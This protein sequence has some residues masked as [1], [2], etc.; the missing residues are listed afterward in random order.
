MKK[1]IF[2]VMLL[3]IVLTSNAQAGWFNTASVDISASPDTVESDQQTTLT[4]TSSDAWAAKIDN[5]GGKVDLNGSILVS[6]SETTTYEIT[7]RGGFFGILCRD[8]GTVTVTVIENIAPVADSTSISTNEDLAIGVLLTGSDSDNDVITFQ[9][10]SNPA[11][12]S[13][14]GTAPNLLYT[15]NADFT[16]VDSFTFITND[17]QVDSAVGTVNIKVVALPLKITILEPVDMSTVPTTVAVSGSLKTNATYVNVA[18]NGEEVAVRGNNFFFI[19]DLKLVPGDNEITVQ[20]LDSNQNLTSSTISVF[21]EEDIVS[22]V[23]IATFFPIGLIPSS[24]LATAT[25]NNI[26]IVPD[27]A[28]I[29]YDGPGDVEITK[30]SDTKFDLIFNTVGLYVLSYSVEDGA[31]GEIYNATTKT[32]IEA[33]FT[34]EDWAA[35]KVAT[36]YLVEVYINLVVSYDIDTVRQRV[37]TAALNNPD[38]SSVELGSHALFVTYKNHI[39]TIIDLTDPTGPVLD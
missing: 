14:N 6:P 7:V 29:S 8:T 26:E 4:W 34:D 16:G 9:I 24:N 39:D 32:L 13:L 23:S 30:I 25:I 22:N 11:N 17:G 19:N 18:V 2:A 33:R 3:G 12:G 10:A 28:S 35:M 27:S 20:A 1:L 21:V 38:F 5:G 31:T 37:L 15:P 36:D